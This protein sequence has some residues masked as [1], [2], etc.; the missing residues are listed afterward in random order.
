MSICLK[1]ICKNEI[2]KHA[3]VCYYLLYKRNIAKTIIFSKDVGK[4]D[5]EVHPVFLEFHSGNIDWTLALSVA[6]G[7]LVAMTTTMPK[8]D[9]PNNNMKT[10]A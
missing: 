1:C 3:H 10:A 9:T 5:H 4:L 6:P 7:S 8:R 2:G